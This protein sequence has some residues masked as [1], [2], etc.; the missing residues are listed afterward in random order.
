MSLEAAS[1]LNDFVS[2][3]PQAGDNV[4]QGDDH[5]RLL[6]SVLQ[7]SFPSVLV[8]KYLEQPRVDLTSSTTPDLSVP[9]SNFI[10]ITGTTQI[11]GFA[12]E[13]DGFTRLIRFANV[14]TLN[15]N[16]STFILPGGDDIITAV[17]DH[18]I[19]VQTPTPGSW[20]CHAYFRASGK[21]VVETDPLPSVVATD[22]GKSVVLTN[23]SPK[24]LDFSFS[25]PIGS[26]VAWAT[27]SPPTGWREC[28]GSS[29]LRSSFPNLFAVLGTTYGAA[30]GTH[31][32]IPDY[33][34]EF[35][36]GMDPGTSRDPDSASR[37]DRGDTTTGANVGTKQGHQFA[38][39][40]HTYDQPNT[41]NRDTGSGA[42]NIETK[43][44]GIATGST[45]GNET[46]PRNVNVKWIIKTD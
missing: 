13:P 3:N 42:N 34:G 27:A 29:L 19:F 11:D 17:D 44:A 6:K 25:P 16:A 26:I 9:A 2:T 37:T 43:T 46:R 12:T 10:N 24:T 1:F 15:Y 4:S 28:D 14:L 18:A 36:R 41:G 23:N 21:A 33:R 22:I 20:R 5:I 39:H 35:L 7:A 40:T 32:N 31:F 38:S 45:G 30:D 8:A